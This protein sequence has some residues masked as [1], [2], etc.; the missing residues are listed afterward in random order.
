MPVFDAFFRPK[1]RRAPVAN[2]LAARTPANNRR[3]A[4][5]PSSVL[6]DCRRQ[7]MR[8]QFAEPLREAAERRFRLKKGRKS[9]AFA[10]ISFS[11]N[12]CF[13]R[14][15]GELHDPPFPPPP[16]S[17][18]RSRTPKWFGRARSLGLRTYLA[19]I[20]ADS[21]IL[22][23]RQRPSREVRRSA[24]DPTNSIALAE[25]PT[26]KRPRPIAGRGKR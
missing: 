21:K 13:R 22:L 14:L 9:F 5:L 18:P 12:Q 23:R 17:G 25:A 15:I 2:R 4:R 3:L 7:V 20:W 6:P 24:L 1:A 10:C 11:G 26:A 19:Q 8:A 16:P